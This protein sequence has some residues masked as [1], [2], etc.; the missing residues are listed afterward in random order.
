MN[1]GL[2][3]LPLVTIDTDSSFKSSLQN[4][5]NHLWSTFYI[6]LSFNLVRLLT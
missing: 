5:E 3:R 2:T 6:F 1:P 4:L